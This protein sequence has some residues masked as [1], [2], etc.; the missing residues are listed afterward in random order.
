MDFNKK[1]QYVRS[2]L[3]LSQEELA[4]RMGVSFA[5]VNRLEQGHHAP[6]FKTQSKFNAMCKKEGITIADDWKL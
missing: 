5:T 2:E 6:S 4:E 1:L 3:I